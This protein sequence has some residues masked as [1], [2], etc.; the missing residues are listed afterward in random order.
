MR[1]ILWA[2]S[3]MFLFL[4]QPAR[5]SAVRRRYI[6]ASYSQSLSKPSSFFFFSSSKPVLIPPPPPPPLHLLPCSLFRLCRQPADS[7]RKSRRNY[8]KSEEMTGSF[9][10]QNFQR[11]VLRVFCLVSR[12]WSLI[13]S[14]ALTESLIWK[15]ELH[16]QPRSSVCLFL[17]TDRRR[18]G[19][20]DASLRGSGAL[21]NT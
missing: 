21:V 1:S 9:C 6:L 14:L 2:S 15:G 5:H 10:S 4:H 17:A 3:S 16:K 7:R 20:Q 19:T 12:F 8:L 13:R 11:S 18:R